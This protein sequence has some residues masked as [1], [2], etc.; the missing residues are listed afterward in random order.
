VYQLKTA[1]ERKEAYEEAKRDKEKI[2]IA[3]NGKTKK[4]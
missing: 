1:E 2:N 4:V 3:A